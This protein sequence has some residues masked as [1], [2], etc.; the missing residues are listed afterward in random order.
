MKTD[1]LLHILQDICASPDF[2]MWFLLS[3]L[4]PGISTWERCRVGKPTF[5]PSCCWRLGCIRLA[6]KR[7]SHGL[8]GLQDRKFPRKV[9][10][11]THFFFK[12]FLE[13]TD[14]YWFYYILFGPCKILQVSLLAWLNL[15]SRQVDFPAL[16][17][18]FAEQNQCTDR[19]HSV[20]PTIIL[21]QHP[22]RGFWQWR[23]RFL[24]V[25]TQCTMPYLKMD[26]L[27]VSHEIREC[28]GSTASR[29]CS[30]VRYPR[31]CPSSAWSVPISCGLVDPSAWAWNARRVR[32]LQR[33]IVV[34]WGRISQ[35]EHTLWSSL[36]RVK[37]PL[38]G[39]K[40]FDPPKLIKEF[41][42]KQSVS[43]RQVFLMI[44]QS[45][46]NQAGIA[47]AFS[48]KELERML[49]K[50]HCLDKPQFL[51]FKKSISPNKTG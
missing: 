5:G 6:E 12:S 23:P 34:V 15:L 33:H 30:V 42:V 14:S 2:F 29:L 47:S 45:I 41:P 43:E 10:V 13:G 49:I 21:L 3:I 17:Q 32:F 4:R 26:G 11:K 37:H 48:Q 36:L 20:N 38:V 31:S 35:Q 50:W 46:A 18:V 19:C 8:S 27:E 22:W 44:C 9:G 39:I 25:G 51:M 24:L 40:D 1:T 16:T 7:R 28:C